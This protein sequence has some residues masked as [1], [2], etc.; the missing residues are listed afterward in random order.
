MTVPSPDMT[1]PG[2]NANA[3]ADVKTKE[4]PSTRARLLWFLPV[5]LVVTAAVYWPSLGNGF[6]NWDEPVLVLQN[7]D[8]QYLNFSSIKRLFTTSYGGL[9]GYTP[10]P[11][12]SF[13]LEY[14]VSGPSPALFHIVNLL[15]HLVN[16]LLVFWL[17]YRLSNQPVIAFVV[18][19]LFGVHPLHVEAVAWIPGRKDLLFVL[20]YLAALIAYNRFLQ[21]SSGGGKGKA[22][23][24][25]VL[26]MFFFVLALFSKAAAIT[27]P[28][29]LFLLVYYHKNLGKKN[30][31]GRPGASLTGPG[32]ALAG[33]GATWV[34]LVLGYLAVVFLVSG[35]GSLPGGGEHGGVLSNLG[36]FF[37]SFVFYIGKT[38]LPLGLSARYPA[39]LPGMSP[40]TFLNIA[41]FILAAAAVYRFHKT[42]KYIVGFGASFFVVTLLPTQAFHFLGQPYTD[43]YM[44]LPMVGLFYLGAVCFH[45][46]VSRSRGKG[47]TGAVIP[48]AVLGAVVVFM[49][50]LTWTNCTYWK[51]SFTLW[52]HVIRVQPGLS[53][54]YLNR[55][56]VYFSRREPAK[57][58]ADF[59]RAVELDPG[60][61]QA[62][63][64]LGIIYY[65][66]KKYRPALEAYNLALRAN[67]GYGEGYFNRA[68]LM[69]RIGALKRAAA[70]YGRALQLNPRMYRA[71][72]FRGVTLRKLSRFPEA[73]ADFTRM[74][75]L[76]PADVT[77]Y[78]ERAD[79]LAVMGQPAEA[80]KDYKK[81][82]RLNPNFQQAYDGLETLYRDQG[83]RQ[84]LTD[85]YRER[86]KRK[87]DGRIQAELER[88][89]G[90]ENPRV[91]PGSQEG[92]DQ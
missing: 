12:L 79:T 89:T 13:A 5:I 51:D 10:I 17:L 64:N 7:P 43:R 77:A 1:S 46:Y 33:P 72:Y 68:N 57:A 74:L 80:E 88:L 81:A 48:A 52:N 23:K 30:I 38:L 86:L 20:F 54:A 61:F 49:G 27:L 11:L 69:G 55:G 90:Q 36:M 47:R 70:D 29:A 15:L 3:S 8:V 25:R 26:S 4:S 19:L 16:C 28:L 41:L 56:D 75:E 78:F 6:T 22:N 35:T 24:F 82:L 18:S 71:Y 62:F 58:L 66:Q 2:A 45:R 50:V 91:P 76:N 9:G 31:P 34:V 65:N 92:T 32:A 21:L 42:S 84:D 60:S 37:Y 85:L 63:N 73:A 53:V 40:L 39:G 87:P 83:R 67:P 14:H 44:Y 59:K